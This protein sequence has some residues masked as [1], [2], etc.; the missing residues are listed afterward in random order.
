MAWGN[1]LYDVGFD[2]P[3]GQAITKFRAVKLTGN[4]EEVSAVTGNTDDIIGFAQYGV[5]VAEQARGKG[6]SVRVIGVTE[7]EAVGAIA[8]GQRVTLEADGRVS[9]L[10]GS[11]G[12]R[13]V[14][15][16][17]GS[18]STNAGDRIALL[19]AQL[20]GTA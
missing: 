13:I 9:A 2:I 20:G 7:A 8:I 18:P 3:S 10:V 16:C 1:F 19:I 14:G 11:S 17:V 5:T 6:A 12:K 4:S 15:K